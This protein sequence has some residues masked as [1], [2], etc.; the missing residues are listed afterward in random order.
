MKKG[1]RKHNSIE[2]HIGYLSVVLCFR[3]SYFCYYSVYQSSIYSS[4]TCPGLN[5]SLMNSSEGAFTHMWASVIYT[6]LFSITCYM[7]FICCILF[8][9][10]FQLVIFIFIY[11]LCSS[12]SEAINTLMFYMCIYIY[13]HTHTHVFIHICIHIYTYMH[14][15]FSN[16][17]Y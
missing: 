17:I 2:F 4:R 5:L 10:T 8:V 16:W 9:I 7:M 3:D 15:Y 12:N 6:V 14:I 13:I 11:I 1:A